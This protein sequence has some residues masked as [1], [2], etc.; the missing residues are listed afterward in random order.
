MADRAAIDEAIGMPKLNKVKVAPRDVSSSVNSLLSI[1][2]PLERDVVDVWRDTST[3]VS[4]AI[5]E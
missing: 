2:E 5:V 3:W 1:V 4:E